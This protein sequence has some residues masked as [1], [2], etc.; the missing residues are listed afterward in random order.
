MQSTP[1]GGGADDALAS[2]VD[3]L[4]DV[5]EELTLARERARVLQ[6]QRGSGRDW[7]DIVSSEERPLIVEQISSAIASLSTAGSQW[8][9]E[10]ATALS[11]EGVSI[12]KIAALYGVTRQRVSA[13]LRGH[14]GEAD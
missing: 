8:R 11:A 5:V 10:Q 7:Y 13:L 14:V 4:D 3:A 9:R 2:L 6:S 12:N 1:L